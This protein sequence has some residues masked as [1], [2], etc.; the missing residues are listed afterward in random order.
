MKNNLDENFECM[1]NP[2]YGLKT[3][4]MDEKW[5]NEENKKENL[6]N[7]KKQLPHNMFELVPNLTPLY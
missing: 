7:L 6:K 3:F 5:K 2:N 1:G 4:W